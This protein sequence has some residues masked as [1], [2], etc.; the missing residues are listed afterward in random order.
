V[1]EDVLYPSP[2]ESWVVIIHGRD[3]D[4][5]KQARDNQK[6][7]E[8]ASFYDEHTTRVTPT[9]QWLFEIPLTRRI[10][11]NIS[12]LHIWLSTWKPVVEKSYNISLETG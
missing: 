4:T 3:D 5:R 10:L 2:W 7:R 9:L 12:T 8:A 6:I 11:G 1:V